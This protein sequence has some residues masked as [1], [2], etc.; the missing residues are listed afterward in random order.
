MLLLPHHGGTT[1]GAVT[2]YARLVRF[3]L[4]G[5]THEEYD[6]QATAIAE[7][8]N[9]WPGLR[10]KLWLAD[11]QTG[12]YGGIYLFDRAEDAELSRST[13]QFLSV[14]MLPMFTE[15]SIEEFEILDGPTAITGGPFAAVVAGAGVAS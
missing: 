5:P 6:A 2:M 14:Q 7:S 15:L 13:P 1:R 11:Q 4:V 9:E 8:F 3:R 12:R 10:A